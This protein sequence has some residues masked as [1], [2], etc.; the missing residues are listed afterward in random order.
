MPHSNSLLAMGRGYLVEGTP[1]EYPGSDATDALLFASFGLS[2]PLVWL[3][4][5]ASCS[6]D[7]F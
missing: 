5:A 3:F 2:V 4:T 1:G 7:E 6:H